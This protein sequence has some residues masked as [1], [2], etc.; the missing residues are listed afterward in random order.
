VQDGKRTARM[1]YST[2]ALD[3]PRP[4]AEE[5]CEDQEVV[6][7]VVVLWGVWGV[8]WGWLVWRA[9]RGRGTYS[10]AKTPLQAA[11]APLV[12]AKKSHADFVRGSA[13]GTCR[14]ERGCAREGEVGARS[15][16]LLG[17]VSDLRELSQAQC[18][19]VMGHGDLGVVMVVLEANGTGHMEGREFRM[20]CLTVLCQSCSAGMN[21]RW[22]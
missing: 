22:S 4:R 10:F 11:Q 14:V 17:V 6:S 20:R 13:I 21:P 5:M 1:A 15:A 19:K 2:N 9:V 3:G 16:G 12:M 18:G 8:S 7:S